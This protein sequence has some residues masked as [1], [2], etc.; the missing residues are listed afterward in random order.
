MLKLHVTLIDLVEKLSGIVRQTINCGYICFPTPP[1]R[2]TATN[3]AYTDPYR[4][5]DRN[6]YVNAEGDTVNKA[7][8][9]DF[10][11]ETLCYEPLP[12]PVYKPGPA[13]KVPGRNGMSYE[14]E[15][16][17]DEYATSHRPLEE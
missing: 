8:R 14:E 5:R 15:D 6:C 10:R 16:W 7:D 12:C 1:L 2:I 9:A 17:V 11:T 3:F 4:G 13:R